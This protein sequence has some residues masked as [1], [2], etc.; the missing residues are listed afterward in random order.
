[1]PSLALRIVARA[2]LF[3]V[4]KICTIL[5]V[6]HNTSLV[7]EYRLTIALGTYWILQD[8]SLQLSISAMTRWDILMFQGYPNSCG[9]NQT[10]GYNIRNTPRASSAAAIGETPTS[11]LYNIPTT[12]T[13][14]TL[15]ERV[16]LSYELSLIKLSYPRSKKVLWQIHST[17]ESL[18]VTQHSF[19]S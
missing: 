3:F 15:S 5:Y 16:I 14:A 13:F 19:L 8:W 10:M 12:L 9:V 6:P 17:R 7:R 4:L 2:C 11:I 1:M 18:H